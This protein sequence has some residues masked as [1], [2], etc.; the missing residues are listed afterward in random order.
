MET[1]PQLLDPILTEAELDSMY[2]R[3]ASTSIRKATRQ[4]TPAYRAMIEASPFLIIATIGARGIDCSPRGDAPGFVRVQDDSTLLVPERRGN[5][6]LDTLRNV[7]ADPRASLLFMIPGISEMLRVNGRAALSRNP[8]LCASFEVNGS[9]P[10]VV[11]VFEI[12]QV[13][14]QCARAIVRS[15]LWNP[16]QFRE[17]G[18][19]PTAGKMLAEATAG[20]EGGAEYDALLP[21]RIKNS[22]Y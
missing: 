9:V 18:E 13:M 5:N 10:K 21:G 14:F 8:D 4:L 19:V 20:Q 22:L 12:E 6:R 7:L 15:Q 1:M 16:A 3:P 17:P 11:I 2:D